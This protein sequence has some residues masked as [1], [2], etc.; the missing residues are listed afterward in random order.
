M[1]SPGIRSALG[2]EAV[3]TLAL[4]REVAGSPAAVGNGASLQAASV[5]ART[6]TSGRAVLT[7]ISG[8]MVRDAAVTVAGR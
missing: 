7:E 6:R 8:W 3:C 2:E 5:E 1:Y 4:G